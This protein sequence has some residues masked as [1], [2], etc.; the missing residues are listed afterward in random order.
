MK[1]DKDSVN[2]NKNQT[3]KLKKK[4]SQAMNSP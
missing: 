2:G 4:S 3:L 1:R